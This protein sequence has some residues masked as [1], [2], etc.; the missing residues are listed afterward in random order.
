MK[1]RN[2]QLL[3]RTPRILGDP[4]LHKHLAQAIDVRVGLL[5][6]LLENTII[7]SAKPGLNVQESIAEVHILL[8][9]LWLAIIEE[10]EPM[11]IFNESLGD[12]FEI[13]WI[14]WK[15]SSRGIPN[16]A[17][18]VYDDRVMNLLE[19]ARTV[20]IK[21][22]ADRLLQDHL[23]IG[24]LS[25][26][27]ERGH[28]NLLGAVAYLFSVRTQYP[29]PHKDDLAKIFRASVHNLPDRPGVVLRERREKYR[30]AIESL[31]LNFIHE[32][33]IDQMCVDRLL[34]LSQAIE[35]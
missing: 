35:A 26:E 33:G 14:E 11:L 23:T 7:Y 22:I 20:P 21:E 17:L 18:R 9:L 12:D 24:H 15:Q 10:H 1:L 3:L 8:D 2:Y 16:Q 30:G 32:T 34:A 13:D 25:T 4:T 27:K 6:T 28:L 29:Q 5:A 31:A 19:V